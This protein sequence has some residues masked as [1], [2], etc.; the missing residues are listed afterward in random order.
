M[1]PKV[2]IIEDGVT[3][4]GRT[5]ETVIV[6]RIGFIV[7]V[8]ATAGDVGACGGWGEEAEGSSLVNLSLVEGESE[9]RRRR[10]AMRWREERNRR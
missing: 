1:D 6:E 9:E 5:A 2:G 4:G 7:V 8:I 10:V 3:A